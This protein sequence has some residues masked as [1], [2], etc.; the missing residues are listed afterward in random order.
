MSFAENYKKVCAEIES[1]AKA[2][3]RNTNEIRMLAVSKKQSSEAIEEAYHLGI[4]DFGENYVQEL[5]DKQNALKHLKDIRW[6]VIGHLQSNKIKYLEN[7]YAIHSVDSVNIAK[8][9]C[10]NEKLKQTKIFIQMEVDAE[11]ENKFGC[12]YEDALTIGGILRDSENTEW[13]GFMGIG[14]AE[15]SSEKLVHLYENFISQGKKIWELQHSDRSEPQFSLGMSGDLKE[16][17]AA[18]THWVRIGT[19]LFGKRN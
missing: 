1:A 18:G 19:A 4:R 6:H 13:L 2:A 11:D 14:P 5:L 9:I 17:I 10:E 15:A 3:G 8:K 16:A 7:I 12:I